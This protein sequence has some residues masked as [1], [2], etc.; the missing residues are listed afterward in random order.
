[1]S[2]ARVLSAQ[3]FG[4]K[5]T[6]VTVESDVERGIHS[7]A[8]VGLP[9]KAVEES[10][11][12]VTSALRN[13]NLL[14]DKFGTKKITI[15]LAPAEL[16]KEGAYHDVAI[17]LSLLVGEE[18]LQ[19]I[20]DD[21]VFIGELSLDGSVRP[22]KGVLPIALSCAKRGIKTL[23][24]PSENTVEASLVDAIEIIGFNSLSELVEHLDH[25]KPFVLPVAKEVQPS[26]SQLYDISF[27]DI[28]GQESV[29]RALLIAAAGN[30]NVILYGPPGTGKTLLAKAFATLLPPLSK[31]AALEVIGIHSIVG[32]RQV[33]EGIS[34]V[35]PFR[36]PHHTSSYVA[37]IGGGANPRPGEVTLAH[38]GVLFLDEF[39]EFEKR[40]I[41]ALRQPLE[42]GIVTVSRARGTMQFPSRFSLIA[43]MNPCPCGYKGSGV[44]ECVCGAHD[45]LRYERK[46][47]GPLLDRIDIMIAVPHVSY[48]DLMSTAKS[49][50]T[51]EVLRE[52]VLQ[53]RKK[54]YERF[55]SL[56]RGEMTNSAMTTKELNQFVQ[57]SDEVKTI[58]KSSAEKLALSPRAYHR[59]IKLARTVADLEN[60]EAIEIPHILEALQY[61]PKVGE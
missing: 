18:F 4:I 9:D 59:V 33:S 29:K 38:K 50:E 49:G 23:Y 15:A 17:A 36:S 32:S 43:A 6:I 45:I 40:V 13:S 56:K 44:K 54:Q 37:L 42:D 10:K 35:P 58:L 47:S 22:L 57:L 60:K 46:L 39:P 25:K 41:E 48:D 20:P 27:E 24:V 11:N 34:F 19:P 61:R 31:E 30:H 8:V 3:P 55:K 1:M 26:V 53:A 51:S 21:S 2:F 14:P 52:K 28:Q 12:R 16:K 5:G 7:F